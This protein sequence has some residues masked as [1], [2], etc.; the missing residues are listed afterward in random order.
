[1][2][3]CT[4]SESVLRTSITT[5][6]IRIVHIAL[7]GTFYTLLV[8]F[9]STEIFTIKSVGNNPEKSPFSY[10]EP[11]PLLFETCMNNCL[12]QT[13]FKHGTFHYILFFDFIHTSE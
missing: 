13:P 1:M 6:I 3:K 10:D 5:L 2:T 11:M 8:I 12:C 9:C 7:S 4:L